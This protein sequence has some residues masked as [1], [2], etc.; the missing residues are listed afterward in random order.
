MKKLIFIILLLGSS[1]G[2][3]QIGGTNTYEFLNV[4]VSARVGGLGGNVIAVNDNDPTFSLAN[5]S[6]L[7]PEMSGMLT[8]SYLNYFSDINQGYVSYVKDFKKLGTFSA[9]IKYINYG[10]FLETDEGGNE[11]GTFTAS[12]YAVIFGWGKSILDSSFSV[13]ANL[14]P[15]YSSFYNFYSAGIA[16]DLS[17]TYTNKDNGFTAAVVVKNIGTQISTYAD[18]G[19]KEPLPF[20]VQAG[21]S[22]RFKHMPFRLSIDAI[23]LQNWNLSY[24]DSIVETNGNE[25]LSEEDKAERNQTNKINEMFRHLVIGGEFVPSKSFMLRFGFN[26]KRR[27]ELAL[28]NKPGLVGFSWGF[29][30]RVKKFHISYGSAR[31]HLAGSSNHFTITTN[32]SEYYHKGA[33]PKVP[34]EKKV[35]KEKV[36]KEKKPKKEKVKN[37]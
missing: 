9:G 17:A 4:P 27:S 34:K 25:N 16:A 14:K 10:E 28:D 26:F 21:I 22:K 15:I 30:F 24:N 2:F 7:N 32:L 19:E 31:Y 3:A 33:A 6:L 1:L 29:G 8:L 13:G 35:K 5:P 37:G 20:E 36:K 18:N 23:Q 12:E 11:F